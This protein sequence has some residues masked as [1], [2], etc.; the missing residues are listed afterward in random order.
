MNCDRRSLLRGASAAAAALAFPFECRALARADKAIPA[1][2]PRDRSGHQ[3]VLYSDSCSGTAEAPERAANLARVNAIVRR[4][5]PE[6][7]FISFPGDA[8]NSG[9]HPEEWETW[10]HQEMAWLRGKPFPL[11]Q[12]TS[13][14]NT[15]SREAENVFRRF[16]PDIPQNGPEGQKGLAYYLRRSNLLYVSLHHPLYPGLPKDF[17]VAHLD[18]L[19]RVLRE[20]ADC[21][22]KLVVG[23]YPVHPLNGYPAG[24]GWAFPEEQRTV[25]WDILLRNR[26]DAYL[27]SHVL[28]FDVQAH[29]GLLQITSAGAGTGSMPEGT[30]Y[31]HAVQIALDSKG[32]RYQVLDTSG[33]VRDRLSWPLPDMKGLNWAEGDTASTA[34]LSARDLLVLRLDRV[35]DDP[36]KTGSLFAGPYQERSPWLISKDGRFWFGQDHETSRMIVELKLG[37]FGTQRWLGPV[38]EMVPDISWNIAGP[39]SIQLALHPGMGPGGILWRWEDGMQWSSME[40]FSASGLEDFQWPDNLHVA[41]M[42]LQMRRAVLP[43]I[44]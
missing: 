21:E 18:W 6:P 15:N 39:K 41:T 29:N 33:A 13:N 22:Y 16:W 27:C 3:F 25:I 9:D 17:R 1:L 31:L 37:K 12:S 8:V 11:Y 10:L 34:S 30:E 4:I 19:D 44:P 43:I 7:E 32:L 40:T 24:N 28:A 42:A 36:V 35:T 23:H 26:V 38:L 5:R 2:M 20:N 14:H